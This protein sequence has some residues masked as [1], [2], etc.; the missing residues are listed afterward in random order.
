MSCRQDDG[1]RE[2]RATR[3]GMFEAVLGFAFATFDFDCKCKGEGSLV[4]Y[5]ICDDEAMELKGDV[6]FYWLCK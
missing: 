1:Q 2:I 6:A 4:L 5:P 3:G